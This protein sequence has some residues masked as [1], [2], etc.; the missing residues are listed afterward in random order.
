MQLGVRPQVLV[1]SM[2]VVVQ[3][4]PELVVH[5][6]HEVH[7]RDVDYLPHEGHGLRR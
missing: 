6:V 5:V 1:L 4:S 2:M 7:L 3:W